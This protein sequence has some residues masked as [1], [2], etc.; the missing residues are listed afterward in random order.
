MNKKDQNNYLYTNRAGDKIYLGEK[1]VSRVWH[2]Y[3]K[4]LHGKHI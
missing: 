1:R 2:Y 3:N 4:E